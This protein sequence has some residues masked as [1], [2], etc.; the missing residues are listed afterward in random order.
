MKILFQG[1]SI[2]D[3]GRSREDCHDLGQGYPLYAAKY[4]KEA[5]P[6]LDLEFIDLGIS[7][8][9][10]GNLVDTIKEG[11]TDTGADVVSVMIG[12]NDTWHRAGDQKWLDNAKFEENLRTIYGTVKNVMHAKL[13]VL[14]QYLIPDESK[15]YWRVDLDPKIQINRKVAR[16]FADVYVPTDGLLAAAYIGHDP[17]EYAADGVH[18][19]PYGA[20]FIGK[21]YAEA[22]EKIL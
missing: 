19:T 21:L 15:A 5:H 18:P 22:F 8:F 20:D 3:A 2:T 16:E 4:I 1:D 11:F 13:I 9:Q 6:E 12:V 14:E 17:F 7:G 10:T